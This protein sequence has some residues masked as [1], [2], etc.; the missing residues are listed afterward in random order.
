MCVQCIYKKNNICR[1][2]CIYIYIA[3][4]NDSKMISWHEFVWVCLRA[5]PHKN[6]HLI[7]MKYGH[8]YLCGAG[9]AN[10]NPLRNADEVKI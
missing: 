4:N 3:L 8:R 6:K 2:R 10:A 5:I 7:I 1:H 9:Q